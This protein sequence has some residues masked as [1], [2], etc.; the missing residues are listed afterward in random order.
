MFVRQRV[1]QASVAQRLA[2]GEALEKGDE[3]LAL[4]RRQGKG[5][6]PGASDRIGGSIRAGVTGALVFAARERLAMKV[7]KPN[8]PLSLTK[9]SPPDE[10]L[11]LLPS[12]HEWGASRE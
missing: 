3:V 11:H 1:G 12:G 5:P 2:I 8:R 10:T 6:Q 9:S 7:G 4:V